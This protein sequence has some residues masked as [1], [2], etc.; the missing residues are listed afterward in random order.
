MN[1]T[2]TGSQ[3]SSSI[4]SNLYSQSTYGHKCTL[5]TSSTG[6]T[7]MW[8]SA[9]GRHGT[10]CSGYSSQHYKPGALAALPFS[11][12]SPPLLSVELKKGTPHAWCHRDH[13]QHGPKSLVFFA[14][15]AFLFI[16]FLIIFSFTIF[17]HFSSFF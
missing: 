6:P 13:P 11:A 15:L 12:A 3:H 1:T 4:D 10:A 17:Y 2:H 14:P 7:S 9:A 5:H 8:A 16:F